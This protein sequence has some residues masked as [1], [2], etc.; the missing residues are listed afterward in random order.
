M[1]GRNPARA[2]DVRRRDALHAAAGRLA[3]RR[4][5]RARA[6]RRDVRRSRRDRQDDAGDAAPRRAGRAARREAGDVPESSRHLDLDYSWIRYSDM[7]YVAY[8]TS[9]PRAR[10]SV[11]LAAISRGGRAAIEADPAIIGIVNPNSPLVWDFLDGRCDVGLGRGQPADRD[12]A[13]PARGRDR[14]GVGRGGA[15]AAGRR[16]ALGHRDRAGHA[17]RRRLLLR[18]VLLGRRHA[19][20]RAVARDARVGARLARRRPAGAPLRPPVPRRRRA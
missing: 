15:L 17:A 11:E 2:V 16:G 14:A 12:D 4:R 1:Q 9:G 3:V 10:D 13:V 7:P 6:P 18:L 8:G 19:Q 20:R 5:S